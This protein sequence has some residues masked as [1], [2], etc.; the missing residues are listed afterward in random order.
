M[1][2][3]YVSETCVMDANFIKRYIAILGAVITTLMLGIDPTVQQTVV[4]HLGNSTVSNNAT[5]GRAQSYIQYTESE[6]VQTLSA[7]PTSEMI[8][9]VYAGIF[10]SPEILRAA[11]L[12]I[13]SSCPTGN[14][15]FPAFQSLAV[16]SSCRDVTDAL[17][18][19]SYYGQVSNNNINQTENIYNETSLP[20][21]LRLNISSDDQFTSGAIA[22]SGYMS[23][24]GDL[25]PAN[26]LLNFSMIRAPTSANVSASQCFL[27]WCVNTYSSKIENG[28]LQEEVLSSWDG[29]AAEWIFDAIGNRSSG[30]INLAPPGAL[31][32]TVGYYAF[33]GLSSWLTNR[34]SFS[35]SLAVVAVDGLV[36]YR[37][38]ESSNFTVNTDSM[39]EIDMLRALRDS[40]PEVVFANIATSVTNNIR[41][42]NISDQNDD[43]GYIPPIPGVGLA[44][45]AVTAIKVYISVR[46]PYL[47]FSGALVALTL[48]HLASTMVATALHDIPVWKLSILPLLT[49]EL[50]KS[51]VDQLRTA[52][53]IEE[54]QRMAIL[55]KAKVE[56]EGT[57]MRLVEVHDS[58][59]DERQR[60][61]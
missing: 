26:P 25:A 8:G 50:D 13:S 18:S 55:T 59:V 2:F 54:M 21:G 30:R 4:V 20:N 19:T 9:A 28:Q 41:S 51:K 38:D 27:S 61:S 47:A 57:G 24:V 5:L 46:W 45:G 31:N 7:L 48:V 17:N 3:F 15:T 32:F 53:S 35:N 56:D 16:C 29:N 52:R 11:S 23:P 37:A 43:S 6:P 58:Q 40:D 39:P 12:N 36:S 10:G 34:L 49:H 22:A 60:E 14:C 44:N 1:A 42:V 33:F